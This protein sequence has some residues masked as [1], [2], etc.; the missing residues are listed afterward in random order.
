MNPLPDLCSNGYHTSGMASGRSI[1]K[2]RALCTW[3]LNPPREWPRDSKKSSIHTLGIYNLSV[4][5]FSS[6][7]PHSV[8]VLGLRGEL[9]TAFALKKTW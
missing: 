4:D 3:T 8:P 9:S 6:L 5:Q 7:A 1:I 2:Q